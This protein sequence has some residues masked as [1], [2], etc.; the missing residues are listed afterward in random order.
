LLNLGDDSEYVAATDTGNSEKAL[1]YSFWDGTSPYSEAE[2]GPRSVVHANNQTA[3][4]T[5]FG[6]WDA[7]TP[8][9]F[10]EVSEDGDGDPVGDLRV[11]Y[12][13]SADPG[14]RAA[15][16]YYPSANPIGGDIYFETSAVENDGTNDFVAGNYNWLS[17]LH[18]IGHALGLSHPFDGGS[19]D[20]SKLNLNLDS[21]R[22]TVMT[23]VQ[24]D[25]NVYFD[26]GSSTAKYTYAE[27]P[28]LLDIE[29]IEHLYGADNWK[30]NDGN[31]DSYT[32][33]DAG[34]ITIQTIVDS[35]GTGDTLDA[36]AVTRGSTINLTPGTFSSLGLYETDAE[37]ITYIANG[38]AALETTLTSYVA[39][40]DAFATAANQPHYPEYTR[41]ALHRNQDN[42]A[43]AHNTWLENAIGGAGADTITGNSKANEITG[44]G[45][46]DTIDGGA[47]DDVAIYSGN[48]A[49][50]TVTQSGSTVTVAGGADATDTLTNVE[51]LKFDDGVWSIADAIAGAAATHA[52]IAAAALAD[53]ADVVVTGGATYG[54]GGD[55][56]S[57][58][59]MTLADIGVLTQ[60]HSKSAITIL[61]SSLSEIS[62]AR[63]KL[64][65]IMNRL[66][67][68]IDNQSKGGMMSQ[69]AR[70]RIVDTDMAI[71][72]TKLAQ[73]MILS[74]AAQQAINMATQ[75]QA[76]VLY[77]LEA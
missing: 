33:N 29:A 2:G 8:F 76:T 72:S 43:I 19:K 46:D 24:T 25:R 11:A 6:L 38:N 1:S 34:V 74:Q 37:Y 65:A 59:G 63:S 5:V 75:R 64:G 27:T 22:N 18:E 52:S 16:A 66:Q 77:L 21:Q 73:E 13:T 54:E 61:D 48:Y 15:Y 41:T 45:G 50:Y 60:N 51:F 26:Q 31:D 68:N 7:A 17:A 49:T 47:G 56:V 28:M 4:N 71:E 67:H 36:R 39:Q 70:G 12:V 35:G 58:A 30:H 42:V 57:L 55:N 44:N 32:Y 53:G 69:Q 9:A 20:S 14:G 3:L 23:Y 62:S 40:L 10:Y